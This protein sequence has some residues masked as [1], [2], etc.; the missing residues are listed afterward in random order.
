MDAPNIRSVLVRGRIHCRSSFPIR[1]NE[2]VCS[3]CVE[4]RRHRSGGKMKKLLTVL[5]ILS[6]TYP[7]TATA[8]DGAYTGTIALL[9]F[10]SDIARRG[11]CVRMNPDL[12]QN[13]GWTC[14]STSNPLYKEI[15]SLLYV[16]YI[17]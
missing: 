11:V 15:T 12:P 5:L 8:Y 13:Y 7:H 17:T 16:A 1:C 14:L 3:Q 2:C 10:N 6:F 4:V 9:H